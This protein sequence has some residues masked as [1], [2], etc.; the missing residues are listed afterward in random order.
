M[1][2]EMLFVSK[3]RVDSFLS[4]WNF[5]IANVESLGFTTVLL[6]RSYA[7]LTLLYYL[8][9]I[10]SLTYISYCE[11]MFSIPLRD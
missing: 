3:S 2:N 5:A 4:G 11:R 9:L 8:D 10:D 6:E 7:E 1:N